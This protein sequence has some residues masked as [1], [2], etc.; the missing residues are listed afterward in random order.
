MEN[1]RLTIGTLSAHCAAVVDA[2]AAQQLG[3]K[4]DR[5][6]RSALPAALSKAVESVFDGA[7]GVIRLRTLRLELP[8]DGP[9]EEGALAKFLAS[10]I[11]AAIRGAFGR[12]GAGLRHWPSHAA[13]LASYIEMRLGIAPAPDWAFPDLRVF[14][15]LPAPRAAAEIIRSHPEVLAALARSDIA[16]SQ[17]AGVLASFDDASC[18]ALLSALIERPAQAASQEALS[19][20]LRALA[21]VVGPGDTSKILA[22]P[23][24]QALGLAMRVLAQDV[25][26]IPI[27]RLVAAC[28]ATVGAVIALSKPRPTPLGDKAKPRAGPSSESRSDIPKPLASAMEQVMQDITARPLMERMA[29]RLVPMPAASPRIQR[30]DRVAA[31]AQAARAQAGP[32]DLISPLAGLGLL[33]PSVVALRIDRVLSPTALA[34]VIWQTLEPEETEAASRDPAI[35]ALFP[36]DPREIDLDVAQPAVPAT[37]AARLHADARPLFDAALPARRWSALIL[38]EFAGRLPGL[39]K[40]SRLYLQMQFL[41]RPGRIAITDKTATVDL[42]HLPLAIVL[43]MAGLSGGQMPVPHLGGRLLTLDLGEV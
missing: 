20:A 21:E 4:L 5:G 7:G 6:V 32:A 1:H 3:A 37:L 2:A 24:R 18:V 31:R 13:Y 39:R 11:A 38:A 22:A 25:S 29:A 33:L 12:A 14:E 16:A 23:F 28:A 17:G 26:A 35:A 9:F 36:V 41:L 43:R 19:A 15:H 40:S 42:R 10:R 8:F 34:Q 30:D 27:Q